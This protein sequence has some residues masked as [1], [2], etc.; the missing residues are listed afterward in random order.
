MCMQPKPLGVVITSEMHNK[1]PPEILEAWDIFHQWW[2]EN[3]DGE[4]PISRKT[5]PTQV[6]DALKKFTEAPIPDQK[7][8]TGANSCY[9][10]VVSSFLVD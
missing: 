10:L 7:G 5:L 9:I 3:F 4:H 1:Y 2:V 6:S 8:A